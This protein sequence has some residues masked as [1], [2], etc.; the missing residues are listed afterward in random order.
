MKTGRSKYLEKYNWLFL[1]IFG[2]IRVFFS[3]E[4]IQKHECLT[5]AVIFI[6]IAPSVTWKNANNLTTCCGFIQICLSCEYL[7]EGIIHLYCQHLSKA[8]ACLKGLCE[9]KPCLRPLAAKVSY[10]CNQH[11]FSAYQE[12]LAPKYIYI[13]L[14]PFYHL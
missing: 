5:S 11:C 13:S 7:K 2:K 12:L 14:I 3:I 9:N 10:S 8:M 6:N 1:I 4:N